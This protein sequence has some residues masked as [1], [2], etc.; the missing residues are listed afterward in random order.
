[1]AKRYVKV[2]LTPMANTRF[3]ATATALDGASF[4]SLRSQE[5]PKHVSKRKAKARAKAA[6]KAKEQWQARYGATKQIRVTLNNGAYAKGNYAPYAGTNALS[7]YPGLSQHKINKLVEQN[8]LV[9]YLNRHHKQTR[10]NNGK[11]YASCL[12]GD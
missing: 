6:A 7:G 2:G 5:K 8:D 11:K 3:T 12:L 4:Y 1:M 9:G 10:A